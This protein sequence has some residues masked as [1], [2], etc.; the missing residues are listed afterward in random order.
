MD[1][2]EVDWDRLARA[3]PRQAWL[4]RSSLG[5]ALDLLD[6][7]PQDRLLDIGTGTAELLSSLSRH[8][9]R[10]EEAIG[11]DP[12]RNMLSQAGPL[13]GGWRLQRA[14]GQDLPFEDESFDLVT[15]SYV[16]HVMNPD[17]RRQVLAEAARVLRPGGRLVTITITPPLSPLVRLLTAPA[18]W[19]ADRYPSVFIGLR[20]LDPGPELLRAGFSEIDRRRDFRGY[21]ALCLLAAR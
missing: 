10:P 15:A 17:M 20:P 1:D 9:A 13:P 18:R 19:A 2:S 14:D 5:T 11:I 8:R 21:P 12:C 16:L 3:Y 4:E 7:G 6:A